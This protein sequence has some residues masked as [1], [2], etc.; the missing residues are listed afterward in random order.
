MPQFIADFIIE[1]D[2]F[3]LRKMRHEDIPQIVTIDQE[4]TLS[5]W[6][7]RQFEAEMKNS[8]SSFYVVTFKDLVRGFAVIWQAAELRMRVNLVAC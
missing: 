7:R 4:S 5:P 6:T 8:F 3:V 1:D 2:E